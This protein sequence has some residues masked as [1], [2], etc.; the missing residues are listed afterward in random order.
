MCFVLFCSVVGSQLVCFCPHKQTVVLQRWFVVF[1]E[2][3][4]VCPNLPVFFFTQFVCCS[5]K[6]AQCLSQFVC[7]SSQFV[8]CSSQFVCCSS[9]FVCCSPQF[10]CCSPQF[11]AYRSSRQN[12]GETKILEEETRAKPVLVRKT[13]RV[14]H[15]QK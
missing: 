4:V 12:P 2:S 8:R 3:P 1:Q 11:A 6:F 5:L 9:Q 10:A 14:R 7:C 13:W 15:K